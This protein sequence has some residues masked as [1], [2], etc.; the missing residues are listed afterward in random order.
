[1]GLGDPKYK[2]NHSYIIENFHGGDGYTRTNAPCV[3]KHGHLCTNET[4]EYYKKAC[5]DF[6]CELFETFER[7]GK[8][9]ANSSDENVNEITKITP[10]KSKKKKTNSL[11]KEKKIR[12]YHN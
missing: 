10:K 5:K 8:N 9:Y 12:F 6:K 11:K 2:K 4:S 1:M 7:N 3:Y